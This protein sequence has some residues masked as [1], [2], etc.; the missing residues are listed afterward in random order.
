MTAATRRAYDDQR[1]PRRSTAGYIAL[2]LFVAMLV[3]GALLA[4]ALVGGYLALSRN[5][6]P[7]SAFDDITFPEESI[8]Y[9]RTGETELARFG[10]FKRE[11]VSW[12]DL[13][14][15][16][17][18]VD[19]TTAVEDKSFWTNSG[20]D[21]AAIV[22]SG[23]DAL[24]GNAR[25]ASTITQQLVRQRL[26][27]SDLVQSSGRT[28]ERK[29]KEIIQSI[30]L[31]Q[32]N[33]GERGKQ[34]IITA[35]LNQNFYGNNSY[36][37]KAAAQ[38]YFGVALEDLSIS[39]AALLAA[40]PQ[41][42]SSYDLVRNA[43]QRCNGPVNE[44]EECID[45]ADIQLVVPE[46]TDIVRR[47]NLVLDLLKEDRAG[48]SR[49]TRSPTHRSTRPRTRRSCSPRRPSR[50]GSPRTSSGPSGMS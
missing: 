21:P 31:T 27:D 28:Y 39:Q 36:G 6:T 44:A 1:R 3:A 49:R 23:L 16:R 22:A 19:A 13:S 25:G 46:D 29:L 8:L 42:P 43:I 45:K 2:I 12:D 38:S 17:I 11:V 40:L 9:D 41:S 5:L 47:R 7:I 32:A 24:R 14:K 4:V 33:E 20:F 34:Q 50:A 26:L 48:C 15:A 30:R 10:D 35:Y 18:L 37:V